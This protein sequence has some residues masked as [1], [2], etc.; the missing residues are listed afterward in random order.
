MERFGYPDF[1]LASADQLIDG[2]Y[3]DRPQLRAIYDATIADSEVLDW[4]QLA[5][6]EN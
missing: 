2:Q 6:D 1:L 4:M 3:E 5:F